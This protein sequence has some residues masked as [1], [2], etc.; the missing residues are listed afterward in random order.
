MKDAVNQYMKA[1]TPSQS[2]KV[3]ALLNS[4]ERDYGFHVIPNQRIQYDFGFEAGVVILVNYNDFTIRCIKHPIH[5]IEHPSK[6]IPTRDMV[7]TTLHPIDF[8]TRVTMNKINSEYLI[9]EKLIE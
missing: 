9:F 4:L 3:K 1:L 5:C 8:L 2:K 7:F 6:L